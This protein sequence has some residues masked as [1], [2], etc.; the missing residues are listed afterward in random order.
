MIQS[1]L[2]EHGEGLSLPPGVESVEQVVP[3]ELR[4]KLWL[5]DC[6]DSLSGLGQ[7]D[8]LTLENP[9]QHYRI[10]WLIA[11]LQEHK[12]SVAYFKLSLESLLNQVILPAQDQ[13]LFLE[14]MQHRLGLDSMEQPLAG[15][16]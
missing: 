16:L 5:Q 8:E 7:D 1:A 12:E 13:P 11:Y 2:R 4:H 3:D 15:K 9:A 6:F 14:M 10:D